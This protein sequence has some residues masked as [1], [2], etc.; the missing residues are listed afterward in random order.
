M[1][2]PRILDLDDDA[3]RDDELFVYIPGSVIEDAGLS[4]SAFCLL[5][6]I[7]AFMAE[8]GQRTT[9][10]ATDDELAALCRKG[11]RTVRKRLRELETRGH[12]VIELGRTVP[13]PPRGIRPTHTVRW[14]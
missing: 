1:D 3:P 10:T 12:V 2:L 9:C 13:R 8:R 7:L 6:V 11:V 4:S 5:G 14:D